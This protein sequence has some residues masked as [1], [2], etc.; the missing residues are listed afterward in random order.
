MTKLERFSETSNIFRLKFSKDF[1]FGKLFHRP[2]I[3]LLYQSTYY[4]IFW[5]TLQ[6]SRQHFVIPH[7]HNI[8]TKPKF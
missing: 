6:I 5:E 4:K 2:K 3:L 8:T 1:R 7:R